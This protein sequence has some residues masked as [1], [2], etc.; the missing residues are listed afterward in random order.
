MLKAEHESLIRLANER[1]AELS[2]P[3]YGRV[4]HCIKVNGHA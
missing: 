4:S 2:G 1:V 3:I